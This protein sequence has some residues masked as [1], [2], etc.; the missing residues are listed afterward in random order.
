MGGHYRQRLTIE[1]RCGWCC[2]TFFA[3]RKDAK[4]CSPACRQAM[5]RALR[6]AMREHPS[7]RQ[8]D[9]TVRGK[10]K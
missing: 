9:T 7:A 2:D 6:Q 8:H 3:T 10:K 4:F 1:R 5:S